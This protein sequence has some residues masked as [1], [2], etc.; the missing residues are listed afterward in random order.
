MDEK[1]EKSSLAAR[2]AAREKAILESIRRE[3]EYRKTNGIPEPVVR[4]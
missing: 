1:K 4:R 2:D 3:Q